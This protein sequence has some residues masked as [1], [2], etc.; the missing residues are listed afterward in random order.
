MFAAMQAVKGNVQYTEMAGAGHIIT[1]EVYG[2]ADLE[3]WI[4][5]QKRVAVLK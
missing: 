5:K 2:N 1:N 3:E 4:F